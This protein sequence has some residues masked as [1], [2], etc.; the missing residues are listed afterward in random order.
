MSPSHAT[1]K[2]TH[3]L[4]GIWPVETPSPVHIRLPHF[5]ASITTATFGFHAAVARATI[6]TLTLLVDLVEVVLQLGNYGVGNGDTALIEAG[7]EDVVCDVRLGFAADVHDI[8][9]QH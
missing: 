4:N 1:L 8:K 2:A 5:L 3:L 9:A 6:S 7:L